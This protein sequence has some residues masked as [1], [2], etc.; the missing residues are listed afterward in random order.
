MKQWQKGEG[1]SE[2]QGKESRSVIATEVRQQTHSSSCSTHSA[3]AVPP[4]LAG[5]ELEAAAVLPFNFYAALLPRKLTHSPP[6]THF[7][8]LNALNSNPHVPEERRRHKELLRGAE[9]GKEELQKKLWPQICN[10]HLVRIL[11]AL[12]DRRRRMAFAG[13]SVTTQLQTHKGCTTCTDKFLT[14]VWIAQIAQIPEQFLQKFPA[15]EHQSTIWIK[16]VYLKVW[17]GSSQPSPIDIKQQTPSEV[18]LDINQWN[19]PSGNIAIEY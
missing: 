1:K 11:G 12:S 16:S 7:L 17:R 14:W 15:L 4:H 9:D 8:A 18:V 6:R 13:L 2:A 10:S 5:A 19:S 3:P